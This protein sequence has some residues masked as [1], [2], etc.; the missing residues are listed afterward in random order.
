MA[1][2]FLSAEWAATVEHAMNSSVDFTNAAAGNNARL[3]QVVTDTPEGEDTRYYFVLEEGSAQLGLG[4]LVDP[5]A[6][7]TQSYS[8]AVAINKRELPIIGAFM[9]GQLK[10]TGNTM[11]LLQLGG[12]VGAMV[13]AISSVDV[14]YE[15]S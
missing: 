15:S 6:T 10:V 4:E 14:H 2:K 3:Q 1:V 13:Q 5:D 11:K 7:I 9:Q 12:V 8:T